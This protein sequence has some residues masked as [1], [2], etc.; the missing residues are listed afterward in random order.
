MRFEFKP[1]F[2]RSVKSSH[3]RE[4]EEI[5]QVSVQAIDILSQDRVIHKGIGLKRLKGDFW[6]IRKGLKAR[7]LFRWEGDLVEFI[8]AG[9]HNDIRRYLKN[10]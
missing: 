2:D 1:S 4:K 10:I 8:L 3:R 7:I 9:D 6:E 5:K